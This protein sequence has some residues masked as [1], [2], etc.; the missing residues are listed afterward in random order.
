[1][2]SGTQRGLALGV[3]QAADNFYKNFIAARQLKE[4]NKY[5]KLE[6]IV[7]VIMSHINSPDISMDERIK[8]I[9]SLPHILGIKDQGVP[10]SQ[11][12]GLDKMAEQ[13]V[14][15]GET[16]NVNAVTKKL[17]PVGAN[18][19]MQGPGLEGYSQDINSPEMNLMGTKEAPILKRRGE[20]SDADIQLGKKLKLV[21]HEDLVK[22]DQEKQMAVLHAELEDRVLAK[23]GWEKDGDWVLDTNK[24]QWKRQWTN[25]RTKESFMQELPPDVVPQAI[26]LQQEKNKAGGN[27]E[28]I[29]VKSLTDF[30]VGQGQDYDTAHNNALKDF[31]ENYK[32][33][34]EYKQQGVAGTKKI[35][36]SQEEGLKLQKL[37]AQQKHGELVASAN[38]SEANVKSVEGR[39]TT[40]KQD[41]ASAKTD[42]DKIKEDYD[43]EEKE[44]QIAQS[45]YNRASD[46]L[47]RIAKEYE[48]A[49]KSHEKLT[50]QVGT[51]ENNLAAIGINPSNAG[52]KYSAKMTAR[53]NLFKKKNPNANLTDDQIANV[54][55]QKGYKD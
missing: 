34:T 52:T 39:L 41:A 24:K 5:R 19:P 3:A 28:S 32:A 29:I 21:K 25:P 37:A 49:T 15:T 48:E 51:S 12:L 27:K 55:M 30:Y 7:G 26:I 54:L 40:A 45:A 11:Q 35:Q 53:I 18:I 23:Q 44:Y 46:D 2:P 38:A 22:L 13:E 36:P 43:P 16:Q 17:K 8:A 1:M 10:L 20:L 9:D 4:Q 42:F 6:P 47:N 33:G 31:Q 14:D 50:A